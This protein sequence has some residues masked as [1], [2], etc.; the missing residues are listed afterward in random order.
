[1]KVTHIGLK[2]RDAR[3]RAGVSQSELARALGI[4]PQAVQKW[5]AEKSAPRPERLPAIA[6][7]LSGR[8]VTT[9]VSELVRG[10]K[11][12]RVL[13]PQSKKDVSGSRVFPREHANERAK[14]ERGLVPLI[15]WE[16]AATWGLGVGKSEDV[17]DWMEC[18]FSRGPDAF[19]LEVVG[20]SN[21]NPAGPKS[22]G[23]GEFITVDPAREPT[24]RSMVVVRIGNDERAILRQLLMDDPHERLLKVL[25]PSWLNGMTAFP[26]D[27]RIV[28]VVIGKWMPE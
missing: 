25:N 11:Y 14:K 17:I 2:I 26:L 1:M 21:Y 28:G 16:Q 22:Y 19:I 12:E 8:G 13:E 24:N 27:A 9:T 4:E 23:P 18:P 5:E 10:T 6:D 7:A 3:L 20:E 15:S